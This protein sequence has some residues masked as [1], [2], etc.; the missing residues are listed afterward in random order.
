[1][2]AEHPQPDY[3]PERAVDG[4]PDTFW[5]SGTFDP[6]QGPKAERP[7]RLEF[8]FSAPTAISQVVIHPRDD[9]GPK[10]GWVQGAD[11]PQNWRVL[12][13]WSAN[14]RGPTVIEFPRT[15]AK[16]FRLVI[17]DSHDPR[18]P[19]LPRNVQIA[20]VELSDNGNILPAA[21]TS[22]ARVDN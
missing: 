22:L 19:L 10:R 13:R 16:W 3:P 15:T 18:S 14:A 2:S 17:V 11:N 6:G 8:E 1:M 21:G 20:E 4:N 7:V 12:A 5:V 9:Y